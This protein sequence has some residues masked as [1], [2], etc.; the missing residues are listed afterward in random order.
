MYVYKQVSLGCIHIIKL[1]DSWHRHGR[2]SKEVAAAATATLTVGAEIN[3]IG[4]LSD[5]NL[6]PV[7]YIV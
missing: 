2:S 7:L 1:V 5:V 6:E 3:L 4:Q